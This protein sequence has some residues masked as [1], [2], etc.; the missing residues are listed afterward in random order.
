MIN[1]IKKAFWK[2]FCQRMGLEWKLSNGL[3]VEI[4]NVGDWHIYNEIF[5]DGEYA[6]IVE[7]LVKLEKPRYTIV[8]LGAN[9]GYFGAYVC[10][11]VFR[12]Q[13]SSNVLYYAVEPD[14]RCIDRLRER[15]GNV[16]KLEFRL[17][18]NLVGERSGRAEFKEGRESFGSSLQR[19][20][21]KPSYKCDFIDL[22]HFVDTPSVD[23]LKCDIEG[24][25]R[26]FVKNYPCLIQKCKYLAIEWHYDNAEIEELE[27]DL[28]SLGFFKIA[29]QP[30][31]LNNLLT[32]F[33][34]SKTG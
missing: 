22:D 34:A 24:A 8:D 20:K 5:V 33:Y 25:E 14:R 9:V 11:K 18:T 12:S 13:A 3:Q 31:P 30:G 29:S 7:E 21:E 16:K 26:M 10:N 15:F 17:S 6:P 1:K 19:N 23:L 32:A 27:G 2:L 28:H 4:Q